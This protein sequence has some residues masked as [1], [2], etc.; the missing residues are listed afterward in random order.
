MNTLQ[1]PAYSMTV[2]K[3]LRDLIRK[4][5]EEKLKASQADESL[6]AH[7]EG[8]LVQFP[9][10]GDVS[11]SRGVCDQVDLPGVSVLNS[12]LPPDH[13]EL[14]L[15]ELNALESSFVRLRG[16][17]CM[18]LGGTV[19]TNG[20][21]P[22]T[23]IPPWISN[24]MDEVH[25]AILS[26]SGLPRPNHA[27]INVYEPGEGIMAH[28]D[29]P[30]YTPYA[31]VLSLGSSAV[32]D[33]VS[34]SMDRRAV[35]RIYLPVGSLLLFTDKAYGEV[36]HEFRSDKF[37]TLS[38]DVFNLDLSN[39]KRMGESHVREVDGVLVR[40]RRVSITMRH[41]PLVVQ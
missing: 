20:L 34:K 12:F 6:H 18:P 15:K 13:A 16:R 4:A 35:A 21:I 38:A 39:R 1:P 27:L 9:H 7:G 26:P 19:T 33:F 30:A 5:K 31:T 8:F 41:V 14:V 32:F 23:N 29:G 10:H 40:G 3:G 2:A 36:L 24:L 37:D 22:A 28:E 11:L 25:K 17:R